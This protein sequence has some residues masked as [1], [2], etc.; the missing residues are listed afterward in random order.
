MAVQ[1]TA[2]SMIGFG[3]TI[4]SF[5][6]S[7]IDKGVLG[8]ALPSAAPARFG[9]TLISLGVIALALGIANH[10]RYMRELRDQRADLIAKGFM[11]G[12]DSF[13]V[14][15]ALVVAFLLLLLGL[16]AILSIIFRAGPFG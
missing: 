9:L 5:F 12:T 16:V 6:R 2:L 15:L 4:Y 3:F 1:R 14:S 11:T 8:K 10:Y 13:P 7:I